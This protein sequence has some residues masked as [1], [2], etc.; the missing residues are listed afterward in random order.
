MLEEPDLNTREA[1][2]LEGLAE[3][4]EDVAAAL[5]R[6]AEEKRYSEEPNG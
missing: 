3:F 2:R 4:H 6:W 5:R 1:L